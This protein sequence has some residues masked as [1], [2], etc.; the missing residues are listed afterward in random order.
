MKQ[1]YLGLRSQSTTPTPQP[2][3]HFHTFDERK[4]SNKGDETVKV[5]STPKMKEGEVDL[6]MKT[7]DGGF[8]TIK[9]S[10]RGKWNLNFDNEKVKAQASENYFANKRNSFKVNPLRNLNSLLENDFKKAPVFTR[11]KQS[12]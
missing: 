12:V 1:H 3:T 2:M 9:S 8:T 6:F 11:K 5:A 7:A 10:T 4:T